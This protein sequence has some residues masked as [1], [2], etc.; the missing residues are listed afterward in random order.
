MFAYDYPILG[1]FWTAFI[2]FLWI[3]WFM[4]LFRV[5]ADIFRSADLGGVAKTLWIIFVIFLPFL[6]IFVYVIARGNGMTQRS[7]DEARAQQ[8]SFD[9]YVRE[10]ASASGASSTSADEI[11][12]FAG[13]RDQGLITDEEFAAQ[14]AKLLS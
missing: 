5:L 4:L 10:T 11:A 2:F 6:G 7:I 1:F 8:A 13:L 14:K 9:Q 12:K 3:L